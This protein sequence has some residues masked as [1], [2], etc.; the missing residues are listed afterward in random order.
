MEFEGREIRKKDVFAFY[1]KKYDD[2]LTLEQGQFVVSPSQKST[3]RDGNCLPESL[4]DQVQ[5]VP[6][7]AGVVVDAFELRV[8]VVLS[9]EN[10]VRDG[11]LA[12]P[13]GDDTMEVDNEVGT[14]RQWKQRMLRPGV[15]G[16][17]VFLRLASLYLKTDIIIIPAFRESGQN[18]TL[19]YTIIKTENRTSSE[20][21]YLFYFSDSEF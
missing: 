2:K 8:Q 11:L 14:Q 12:W 21:I 10:S 3:P 20:P 1:N 5:Y 16:D 7:L 15:W 17:A 9:L 18:T 6:E 4:F 13:G 19:G